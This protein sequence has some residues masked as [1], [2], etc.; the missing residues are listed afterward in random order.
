M[1]TPEHAFAVCVTKRGVA[2]PV[3]LDEV[4]SSGRSAQGSLAVDLAQSDAVA[5]VHAVS[6]VV[7]LAGNSAP[8]T[9]AA[10]KW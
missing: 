1:L 10:G 7:A 2:K 5:S 6:P 8:A 4:P 9:P 3:A